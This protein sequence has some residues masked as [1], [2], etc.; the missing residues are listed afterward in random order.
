MRDT[1][2]VDIRGLRDARE[3]AGLSQN[4]LAELLGVTS[5]CIYN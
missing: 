2:Y 4:A 3:K 5:T 1:R